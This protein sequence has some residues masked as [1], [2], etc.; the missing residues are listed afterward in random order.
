MNICTNIGRAIEQ[1][2][3]RA[4]LTYLI[5]DDSSKSHF[6]NNICG[7]GQWG[8]CFGYLNSCSEESRHG[9]IENNYSKIEVFCWI[10]IAVRRL[11]GGRVS[12]G[13]ESWNHVDNKWWYQTNMQLLVWLCWNKKQCKTLPVQHFRPHN[14]LVR[15]IFFVIEYGTDSGHPAHL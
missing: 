1:E 3:A 14:R 5:P 11:A 8:T 6:N 12:E 9:Y 10:G 7:S 2:D 4:L 13:L 15:I